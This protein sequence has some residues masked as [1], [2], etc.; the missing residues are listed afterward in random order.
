MRD[1]QSLVT[2]T[3]MILGVLALSGLGFSA[4]VKESSFTMLRTPR[5][6]QKRSLV[7]AIFSEPTLPKLRHPSRRPWPY[8]CLPSR[9]P[10]LAALCSRTSFESA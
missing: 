2:G 8:R 1:R 9:E 5:W 10:K 7:K 4:R 3:I 6:A